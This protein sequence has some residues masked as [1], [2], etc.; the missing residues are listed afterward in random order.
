MDN[1]NSSDEPESEV[2]NLISKSIISRA[3]T[4]PYPTSVD[5]DLGGS[6]PTNWTID[7]QSGSGWVFSGTAGYHNSGAGGTSTY[8]WV[9]FSGSDVSAWMELETVDVG[10]K[11]DIYLNLIFGAK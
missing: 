6:Q 5:V 3:G 4:S 11:S 10:N 9:D 2:V 1:A 8:A 7:E